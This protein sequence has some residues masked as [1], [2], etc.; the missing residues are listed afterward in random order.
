MIYPICQRREIS[1]GTL[2][3]SPLGLLP[4]SLILEGSALVESVVVDDGSGVLV[5]VESLQ[6]LQTLL[7]RYFLPNEVER[8][9]NKQTKLQQQQKRQKDKKNIKIKKRT[10]GS[11]QG[12]VLTTQSA[13]YILTHSWRICINFVKKKKG[14][15]CRRASTVIYREHRTPRVIP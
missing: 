3:V 8:T 9:N 11:L 12:W 2:T 7:V 1:W 13:V 15:C 10:T 4:W 14:P 5:V 6:Q